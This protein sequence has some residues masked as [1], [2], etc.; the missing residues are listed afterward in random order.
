MNNK[1]ILYPIIIALVLCLG[2]II[3]SYMSISTQKNDTESFDNTQSSYDKLNAILN[4]LDQSYVDN[5]DRNKLTEDVLP[6]ILSNLDPHSTYIPASEVEEA[7]EDLEG[8]FSGIGV[9]F[10]IQN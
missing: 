10:N 8:S 4:L 1:R 2:M 9:Q 3:G 5:I 7:N 6:E